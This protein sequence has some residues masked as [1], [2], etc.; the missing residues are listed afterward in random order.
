MLIFLKKIKILVRQTSLQDS[1]GLPG[2][3][4][5]EEKKN[6]VKFITTNSSPSLPHVTE[7]TQ[8]EQRQVLV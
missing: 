6:I 1:S 4:D 8:V 2:T 5:P 7:R 3:V